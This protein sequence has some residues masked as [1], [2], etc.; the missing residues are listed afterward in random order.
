LIGK[1]EESQNKID[2]RLEEIIK[3]VTCTLENAG[4]ETARFSDNG[5]YS[6]TAYDILIIRNAEG[7]EF[8]IAF[9]D[10]KEFNEQYQYE[11]S[12]KFDKL[13]VKK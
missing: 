8:E 13:K 11:N 6:T 4:F 2:D 5:R 10:S 3:H 9:N 7:V 1:R 12:K